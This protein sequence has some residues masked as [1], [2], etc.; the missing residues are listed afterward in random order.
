MDWT[1]FAFCLLIVLAT[2]LGVIADEPTAPATSAPAAASLALPTGSLTT[3][4]KIARTEFAQHLVPLN[5][6]VN[7]TKV[8]AE[9]LPPVP[10][11]NPLEFEYNWPPKPKQGPW[12]EIENAERNKKPEYFEV[13]DDHNSDQYVI[14]KNSTLPLTLK[15]KKSI[16]TRMRHLKLKQFAAYDLTTDDVDNLLTF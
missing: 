9:N 15:L 13:P 6:K 7:T 10:P 1:K 8:I 4:Q 3:L 2:A 12:S 5:E 16:E 14:A 11:A